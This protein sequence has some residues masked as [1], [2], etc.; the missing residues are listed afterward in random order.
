MPARFLHLGVNFKDKS[1]TSEVLSE[2]EAVLDSGKDWYRYAPNCWIVYTNQ[3]AKT[4]HD[5]LKEI[6]WMSKQSYLV[7]EINVDERSGWLPRDTWDWLKK[8]RT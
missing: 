2:I 5:R 8:D 7:I 6:P 4:W 1:P 3:T